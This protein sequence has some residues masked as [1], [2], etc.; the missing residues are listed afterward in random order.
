MGRLDCADGNGFTLIEILIAMTVAATGLLSL[1]FMQCIAIKDNTLSGRF[2]QATF[3]AQNILE[4]VKDGHMVHGGTFG[5][6]TVSDAKSDMPKDTGVLIGV[7]QRGDTGGS[8]D[9]KWQVADHTDWS[10]KV[11]VIVSWESVQGRKRHLSLVS[12]SR[13]GGT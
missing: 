13:G 7:N 8:F 10:R 6:S 3:L 2:T 4:C 12:T 1:A 9:V 5:Y 11:T